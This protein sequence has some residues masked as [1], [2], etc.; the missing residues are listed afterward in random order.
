MCNVSL[1]DEMNS[2]MQQM[3]RKYDILVFYIYL[4]KSVIKYCIFQKFDLFLR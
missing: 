1:P 2:N 3:L 4:A